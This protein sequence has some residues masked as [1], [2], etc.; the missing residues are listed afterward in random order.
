MSTMV[1]IMVDIV[2]LL[3][4]TSCAKSFESL[5]DETL[6]Y[7]ETEPDQVGDGAV[8]EPS[9]AGGLHDLHAIELRANRS[10]GSA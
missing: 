7:R 2:N 8:S 1:L 10:R 4:K 3:C 9:F 6:V 5:N